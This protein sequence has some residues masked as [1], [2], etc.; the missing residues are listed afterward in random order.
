VKRSKRLKGGQGFHF[1][2]S[3]F[4][5]RFQIREKNPKNKMKNPFKLGLW[6]R[7]RFWPKFDPK[8]SK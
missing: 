6:P 1:K 5:C 8:E 4:P 3:Q 7:S 2:K